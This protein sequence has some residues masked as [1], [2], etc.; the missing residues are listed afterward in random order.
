MRLITSSSY[1]IGRFFIISFFIRK[2]FKSFA[3]TLW[4][5][6]LI[7]KKCVFYLRLK[8]HLRYFH[9]LVF[10]NC[11]RLLLKTTMNS[12]F[13]YFYKQIF[14]EKLLKSFQSLICDYT[15][16]DIHQNVINITAICSFPRFWFLIY[17]CMHSFKTHCG[18][19]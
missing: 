10:L 17:I 15:N 2:L 4:N 8:T 3:Q 11:L 6:Y 19:G 7:F 5:Y 16:S 18:M 12:K 1:L 14:C 9:R 13:W